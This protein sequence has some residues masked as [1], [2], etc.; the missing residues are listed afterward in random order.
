MRTVQHTLGLP[1]AIGKFKRVVACFGSDEAAPR[2]LF[3]VLCVKSLNKELISFQPC[4]L[5]V[6]HRTMARNQLGRLVTWPHLL[7]CMSALCCMITNAVGNEQGYSMYTGPSQRNSESR[8]RL[9]IYTVRCR[10][11]ADIWFL[12]RLQSCIR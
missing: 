4:T 3:H 10:A 5:V 7:T 1:R 8:P 9:A 6:T 11:R 12:M 2:A